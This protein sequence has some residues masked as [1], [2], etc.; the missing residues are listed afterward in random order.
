MGDYP[1]FPMFVDLSGRRA[2]IVGGGRVATR[3]VR[4]LLQFCPSVT[5]VA[6]RVESDLEA[7]AGAGSIALWRRPYREDDLS[8]MDLALACADDAALNAEIAAECRR[9]GIPVNVA[10]DRTLCDFLF[11]GI[12]RKDDL[13]LGITAGGRDHALARRTTEALR[14]WIQEERP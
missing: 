10:S 11:P 4:T 2:L 12:A 8:G 7:L 6:P 9:R 3:R 14:E 13:V 1:F 5:V